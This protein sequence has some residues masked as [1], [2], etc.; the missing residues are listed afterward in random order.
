VGGSGAVGH[1]QNATKRGL[2]REKL[3][4]NKERRKEKDKENKKRTGWVRSFKKKK[5]GCEVGLGLRG[6]KW[7][8]YQDQT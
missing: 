5:I 6:G 4:T 1:H 8:R 7:A 3:S 2:E